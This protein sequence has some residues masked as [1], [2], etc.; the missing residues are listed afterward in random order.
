MGRRMTLD[1]KGNTP[2]LESR[3]CSRRLEGHQRPQPIVLRR[4]LREQRAHRSK[5]ARGRRG[6]ARSARRCEA[7]RGPFAAGQPETRDSP[8]TFPPD[9]TLRDAKPPPQ[10]WSRHPRG[11]AGVLRMVEVC[12]ADTVGGVDGGSWRMAMLETLETSADLSGFTSPLLALPVVR[13][14]PLLRAPSKLCRVRTQPDHRPERR[15]TARRAAFFD[16]V[17]GLLD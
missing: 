11:P 16:R 4:S 9:R 13:C 10:D 15:S 17:L 6:D 5:R 7:I 8:V 1:P 14:S 3:A 2:L 12:P